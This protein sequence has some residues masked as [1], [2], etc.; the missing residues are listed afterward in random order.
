MHVK[1]EKVDTNLSLLIKGI[2]PKTFK[3]CLGTSTFVGSLTKTENFL[4]P[5]CFFKISLNLLPM[6]FFN[7]A[8]D[9]NHSLL[10][11]PR[12]TIHPFPFN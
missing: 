8:D 12:V 6:S 11:H 1:P 3:K 4:R 2:S 7:F 5:T 10:S 9:T